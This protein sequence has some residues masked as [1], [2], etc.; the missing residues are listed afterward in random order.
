LLKETK[1]SYFIYEDYVGFRERPFRGRYRNVSQAGFREVKNQGPWP[2]D[3]RNV[4]VFAFGGS[5]M[6]GWG[7]P[8]QQTIPSYLQEELS[9]YS[10]RQVCVYNFGTPNYHCKQ[11]RVLLEQLLVEGLKPDI[12]I[13]LDGLNDFWAPHDSDDPWFRN[14]VEV[15]F[16]RSRHVTVA[17]L[18]GKLPVA[19]A[20]RKVHTLLTRRRV[21][22][23]RATQEELRETIDRYRRNKAL[24][25]SVLHTLGI[26]SV[27][28]WQPVPSY[29]C[30]AA[31]DPFF[32]E[33]ARQ[34]QQN[35]NAGYA[36]MEQVFQTGALGTNLLWCADLQQGEKECLYVDECHYT[37]KFSRKI[38]TTIVQ[39]CLERGL[40]TGS[41]VEALQPLGAGPSAA[42]AGSAPK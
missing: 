8:D 37:A 2:P 27:F 18:L 17:Y 39:M 32:D 4:N 29:K 11:E 35:Q 10:K 15:A 33:N 1:C 31:L 20:A 7:L 36:M 12:A 24:A 16:A 42:G 22:G 9:R 5:T 14:D 41:G 6:Y 21:S 3:P 38:A 34:D 26:S 19:R 23:G 28:V 40:L 25:E 30:D 13:F